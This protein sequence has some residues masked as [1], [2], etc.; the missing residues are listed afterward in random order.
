MAKILLVGLDRP[1]ADDLIDVL[2]QL[3][4]SVQTVAIGCGALE[5]GDANLIFAASDDLGAVGAAV[6]ACPSW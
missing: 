6:P 1:L 2:Q 5:G 4:Q 3:G